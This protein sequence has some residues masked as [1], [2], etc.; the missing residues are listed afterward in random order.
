MRSIGLVLLVGA[1]NTLYSDEYTRSVGV[2]L[3][4]HQNACHLYT[5]VILI[6]RDSICQY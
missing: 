4:L 5:P 3:L 2:L 6:S 1:R